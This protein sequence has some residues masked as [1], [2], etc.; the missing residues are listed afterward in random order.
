MPATPTLT[1]CINRSAKWLKEIQLQNG[2]W[3]AYQGDDPNCLNTSEVITAL[4]QSN[5]LTPVNPRIRDGILFLIDQQLSISKGNCNNKLDCGSWTKVI[6]RKDTIERIP[7][8]L[9]TA[10][11]LLALNLTVE[12][13]STEE[14]NLKSG[15]EWLKEAQREDGGWGYTSQ[16]N[17][18]SELFPTC[19]SLQALVNISCDRSNDFQAGL[20]KYIDEGFQ[21]LINFRHARG[22]F[23]NAQDTALRVSHTFY[24]IETL[25]LR[26]KRDPENAGATYS[27][28]IKDG[29]EW[30][31]Q[32]RNDVISWASELIILN[33]KD[34]HASENYTFSHNNAALYLRIV[35]PELK[36]EPYKDVGLTRDALIFIKKLLSYDDLNNYGFCGARPV[37][38]ATAKT[39]KALIAVSSQNEQ[40]PELKQLPNS[41]GWKQ[42][43]FL[44][45]LISFLCLIVA[46]LAFYEKLN[47]M[48]ITF[49]LSVMFILLL[50]YGYLSEKTFLQLFINTLSRKQKN[51]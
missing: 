6:V 1:K 42:I 44:F 16:D 10:Y 24:A 27:K 28:Y 15:V 51:I 48:V 22:Y 40:F 29:I 3:G 38:W 47:L 17:Q 23:G 32:Q 7:D 8:T 9:R 14:D 13:N 25:N 50:V 26:L 37:S 34:W 43:I 12:P 5:Q 31:T 19:M 18:Q 39:I 36:D 33:P 45:I 49:Y 41:P 20:K 11:A 21:S 35:S 4:I 2:G 46:L 30:L